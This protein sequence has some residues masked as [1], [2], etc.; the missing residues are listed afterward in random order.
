MCN[1]SICFFIQQHLELFHT[2]YNK[3]LI[4]DWVFH[5]TGGLYNQSITISI[6]LILHV[7]FH[8]KYRVSIGYHLN[9]SM[10]TIWYHLLP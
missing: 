2:F 1:G 8:F 5:T 3:L 6:T 7:S 4:V 10:L 9:V